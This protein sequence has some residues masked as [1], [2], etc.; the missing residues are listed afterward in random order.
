MTGARI[1]LNADVSNCCADWKREI[2]ILFLEGLPQR[3][4]LVRNNIP[5]GRVVLN[6]LE[7]V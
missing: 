7:V 5:D 2:R 6:G 1:G 4:A 3:L